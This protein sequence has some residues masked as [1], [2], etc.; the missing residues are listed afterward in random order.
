[1]SEEEKKKKK[2]PDVELEIVEVDYDDIYFNPDNPNVVDEHTMKLLA[3]N[4]IDTGYLE[5]AVIVD[6]PEYEKTGK[7]YL[8][9]DGEH[10]ARVLHEM[11]GVKKFPAVYAKGVK[12]EAGYFGA[13][14]FNKI[15]GKLDPRRISKMLY[16]GYKKWGLDIV[17]KYSKLDKYKLEEYLEPYIETKKRAKD[18]A[19]RERKKVEE[20]LRGVVPPTVTGATDMPE[21][22]SRPVSVTKRMLSFLIDKD[23]YDLVKEVLDKFDKK[24]DVAI[25]KMAK[26]VK[27]HYTS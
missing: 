14:T 2:L 5:P 23:D 27:A 8:M 15:R 21:P 7:K 4:I 16:E 19:V 9:V 25:V 10:R 11:L 18:M 20:V 22:K 13:L 3:Q 24:H 17:R 26:F 6:N 1:M 12:V